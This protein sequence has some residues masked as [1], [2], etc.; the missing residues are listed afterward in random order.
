MSPAYV[1]FHRPLYWRSKRNS[2]LDVH[3]KKIAGTQVHSW[4]SERRERFGVA[5]KLL[6]KSKTVSAHHEICSTIAIE[7]GARCRELVL[8]FFSVVSDEARPR[9]FLEGKEHKADLDIDF[10]LP[11]AQVKNNEGSEWAAVAPHVLVAPD[12][13]N[14]EVGH[15]RIRITGLPG[16]RAASP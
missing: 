1:M 11:R 4:R 13:R 7:A 2:P 15:T 16:G 14:L 6:T 3:H 8:V 10:A 12:E 5:G 9:V